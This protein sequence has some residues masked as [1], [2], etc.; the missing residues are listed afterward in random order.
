L[1][2]ACSPEQDQRCLYCSSQSGCPSLGLAQTSNRTKSMLQRPSACYCWR[3]D[4]QE[5]EV[6]TKR[7][8][9]F[10]TVGFVVVWFSQASVLMMAGL[11]FGLALDW[12]ISCDRRTTSPLAITIPLWA[13]GCVVALLAGLRSMT[14]ATRQFMHDFWAGGSLPLPLRLPRPSANFGIDEHRCFRIRRCCAIAIF[15]VVALVGV[16]ISVIPLALAQR[17]QTFSRCPRC[18]QIRARVAASG[19]DLIPEAPR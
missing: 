15:V 5:R 17:Q 6:S 7:L 4:M 14:P 18:P 11:G 13:A 1:Q 8:L 12:L 3:N 2:S 9:L 16:T 10:D 19:P